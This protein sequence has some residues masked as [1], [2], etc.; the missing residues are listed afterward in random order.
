MVI[1]H[2]ADWVPETCTLPTAQRPLRLAEF[3][4]FFF[5][6]ARWYR[7]TLLTRLDV[8]IRPDAESAGRIL[9]ERE[10]GCCS[11]FTFGFEPAGADVVIR[12][13]VPDGQV[14]VLDALQ[15][16]VAA[17]VHGARR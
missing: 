2:G 6:A 5:S 10:S 13:S 17:A 4:G 1:D 8:A 14:P 9:A 16:R 11:F 12:I 7:R 15:A 3:D